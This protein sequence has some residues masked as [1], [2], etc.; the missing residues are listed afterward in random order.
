MTL[1]RILV[2]IA[3]AIGLVGILGVM[4]LETR[5][6]RR[7]PWKV[8]VWFVFWDMFVTGTVAAVV[9]IILQI[10]MMKRIS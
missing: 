3:S 7:K 8:R 2:C 6:F 10:Y 5:H 1:I 9:F 4:V